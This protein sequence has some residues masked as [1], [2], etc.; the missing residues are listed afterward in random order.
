[1]DDYLARQG[2][3]AAAAARLAGM[4][5]ISRLRVLGGDGFYPVLRLW[6]RGFSV[7]AE[8]TPP[9]RGL[10]E[11]YDGETLI[12]HCLVVATDTA[13]GERI[14]EFKRATRAGEQPPA[15]WV[16]TASTPAGYLT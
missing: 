14:Y 12:Q 8:T 15:D 10:V 1:M 2:A 11:I 7:E 16:R 13:D 4:K 6:A 3:G 5:K 9:L